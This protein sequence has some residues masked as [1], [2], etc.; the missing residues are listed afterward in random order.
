[1]AHIVRSRAL[2]LALV[3]VASSCG[4]DQAGPVLTRDALSPPAELQREVPTTTSSTTTVPVDPAEAD[5]RARAE[6]RRVADAADAAYDRHGTYDVDRSE[7]SSRADGIEVVSLED[8]AALAGVVYDPF[9]DRVTVHRESESGQ[10]FCIDL[11]PEGRDYGFGDS[12]PNSLATCTDGLRVGGWGNAFSPTGLD[13][14]AVAGV[15]DT[16]VA[17]AASG[18]S[19]RILDLFAPSDTCGPTDFEALWPAGLVLIGDDTAVLEGVVVTG[20]RASLDASL[21]LSAEWTLRKEGTSWLFD[22]DPCV[23]FGTAAT[24]AAAEAAEALLEDALFAVRSVFVVEQDFA[25]GSDDLETVNGDLQWVDPADVGFGLLAYRGTP[26]AGVVMTATT[27]GVICAVESA[28]E[29][30]RYGQAPSAQAIRT[31]A[32]CETAP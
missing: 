13:E 30:T 25:F 1:M 21:G 31:P 11:S 28:T 7:I 17:S 3:V 27:E 2:L 23:M 12:F 15:W 18:D 24:A 20:S 26:G 8:A 9:G 22:A 10:W 19:A 16:L 14:A 29:A 32:G 5:R 4:S 6:L